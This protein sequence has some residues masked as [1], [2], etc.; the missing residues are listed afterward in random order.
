MGEAV[1]ESEASRII[2]VP[3]SRL[4]PTGPPSAA[5]LEEQLV[6]RL[7]PE[8]QVPGQHERA[9]ASQEPG[10]RHSRRFHPKVAGLACASVGRGQGERAARV[11]QGAGC[12]GFGLGAGLWAACVEG[13]WLVRGSHSPRETWTVCVSL[14]PP[15]ARQLPRGQDLM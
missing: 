13:G 14:V 5:A 8:K 10:A 1:R 12:T 3:R 11:A 4:R 9:S 6:W 2:A 7:L 15:L